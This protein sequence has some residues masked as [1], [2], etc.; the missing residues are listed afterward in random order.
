MLKKHNTF[1]EIIH[2]KY[3]KLQLDLIQEQIDK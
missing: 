2:L 1:F 3:N